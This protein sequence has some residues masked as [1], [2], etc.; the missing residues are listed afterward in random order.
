MKPSRL[1]KASALLALFGLLFLAGGWICLILLTANYSRYIVYGCFAASFILIFLSLI[2]FLRFRSKDAKEAASALRQLQDMGE[3]K[4]V[5]RQLGSASEPVAMLSEAINALP[6]AKLIDEHHEGVLPY[7]E[8]D[9]ALRATLSK[10]S[11]TRSCLVLYGLDQSGTPQSYE[12]L[13][14]E[15]EKEHEGCLLGEIKGGYCAF[16]PYAL[17]R[18]ETEG[19]AKA[20]V[21]NFVALENATS[22]KPTSIGAK[23]CLCF[24]P[25][26]PADELLARGVEGL[27]KAKPIEVLSSGEAHFMPQTLAEAERKEESVYEEFSMALQQDDPKARKR[28]LRLLLIKVG[29]GLGY[30][31]VGLALYDGSRGAYRI[32]E[33]LHLEGKSR[34]FRALEKNGFV[35]ADRIDPYYKLALGERLYCVSDA[36]R[37]PSRPAAIL[38]SLGLHAIAC[39]A[40]GSNENKTGF[41]YLTA[42][43]AI[44]PPNA[45]QQ[46]ALKRFFLALKEYLLSEKCAVLESEEARRMRLL[47]ENAQRYV[48]EIDPSTHKL[49]YLSENLREAFPKVRLGMACHKALLGLDQPCPKC[50]LVNESSF[51]KSLPSLGPGLLHFSALSKT[52]KALISLS[53]QEHNLTSR[54]LDPA[55]YI[56]NRRALMADLESSLLDEK[57]GIALLFNVENALM[58]AGKIKDGTIDDVMS[59]VVARLSIASLDEGLYRFND[60]CL[61]YLLPDASKEEAFDVAVQVAE[62]LY[63]PVALQD[64]NFV[65][66]LSFYMFDYPIE[67]SCTFDLESL[68]RT[69]MAKV[70][71]IGKGRMIPFDDGEA[72]LVLPRT[73]KEDKIKKALN[74]GSFPLCY[75]LVRENSSLR[76]RYVEV[77][78]GL[79]LVKGEHTSPSDIRALIGEDR[80]LSKLEEGE[81]QSFL[82]FYKANAKTFK[83]SSVKGV[84]LHISKSSLFSPTYMRTL[85]R[86]VKDAGVPKHY[87]NLYLIDKPDEKDDEKMEKAVAALEDIKV[88]L[89]GL[90]DGTQPSGIS[91]LR[92]GE[93]LQAMSTTVAET[94]L[95]QRLAEAKGRKV[96][97]VLPRVDRLEEQTYAISL[98]IPYGAGT[99]YGLELSE[100]EFLK[101]IG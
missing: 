4:V 5:T 41:I 70:P 42:E 69:C 91:Y 29:L 67:V 61:A 36:L 25:D 96:A 73:Y 87:I 93:L 95:K 39:C 23:A 83:A 68:M 32:L 84:V 71:N 47:T 54:R 26:F 15:V 33:E 8:F 52:P 20:F 35:A 12:K 1:P 3:G 13:R 63:N 80:M 40:I 21:A 78:I 46:K 19:R 57:R 77:G 30:D 31:Q 62:E 7:E 51:K 27:Q 65:P 16:L 82:A 86:G 79:D 17:S 28:A 88:N 53:K 100:E 81:L 2:L 14:L 64:R 50:P 34:A 10:L 90:F 92:E 75:N 66:E 44:N 45:G 99:L 6:E 76:V 49:L 48:Y 24:Y 43:N 101:T 97:L 94:A 60:S 11:S 74:K 38:D 55:L 85:S 59:A 18:Q 9:K 37:L 98:A 58:S 56:L 22:M 89:I 72:P